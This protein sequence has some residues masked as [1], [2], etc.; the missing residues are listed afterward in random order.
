MRV[1]FCGG[2][3]GIL[4]MAGR[5]DVKEGLTSRR[6]SPRGVRRLGRTRGGEFATFLVSSADWP[7]RISADGHIARTELVR[8]SYD[9]QAAG[10]AVPGPML[11]RITFISSPLSAGFWKN[12]AAPALSARCSLA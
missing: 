9:G 6:T 8:T 10:C 11:T 7:A 1:R 3:C 2:L 4:Y 5:E 12:A